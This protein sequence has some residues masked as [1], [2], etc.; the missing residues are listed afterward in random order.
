MSGRFVGGCGES[1]A[2]VGEGGP[3]GEVGDFIGDNQGCGL[4]KGQVGSRKAGKPQ[5]GGFGDGAKGGGPTVLAKKTALSRVQD[6][7]LGFRS[8]CKTA[9]Q[10]RCRLD[11]FKIPVFELDNDSKQPYVHS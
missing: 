3:K 6:R 10:C 8:Q 2:A 7:F 4:Q 9:N 1:G 11:F 5:V